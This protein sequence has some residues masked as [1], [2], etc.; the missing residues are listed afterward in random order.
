MQAK[1]FLLIKSAGL[2]NLLHVCYRK[3]MAVHLVIDGYNLTGVMAISGQTAADLEGVR[4]ELIKRLQAYK[5]L[6]GHRITV[7][8]DGKKSGSLSRAK[9]HQ[10][11]IEVIF[12]KDGEEADQILREMAKKERHG[13]TIVTSD[14]AVASFAEAQGAVTIPSD[15]FDAILSLAIYSDMT[16]VADEDEEDVSTKKSGNPRKLSKQERKR[17]Q[18]IKKL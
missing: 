7:V 14:R 10:N 5:R 1:K 4:D 9:M 18:R 3:F 13:I 15:E 6:K 2:E 8:F 11:G 16:G 12:S 17:L